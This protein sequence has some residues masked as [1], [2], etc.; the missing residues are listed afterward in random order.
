MAHYNELSCKLWTGDE[1]GIEGE[2]GKL[3]HDILSC[4]WMTWEYLKQYFEVSITRTILHEF[5][6]QNL[7]WY[8]GNP[9]ND[10]LVRDFVHDAMYQNIPVGNISQYKEG[11]DHD[12]PITKQEWKRWEKQ[13][14][15]K[16]R[17]HWRLEKA[18]LVDSK[19]GDELDAESDLAYGTGSQA[20]QSTIG[21]VPGKHQ[22]RS[23][24]REARHF[25]SSALVAR[26]W[27]LEDGKSHAS[28]ITGRRTG[29]VLIGT[30]IAWEGE[31][32]GFRQW[33]RRYKAL[34]CA[35]CQIPA[36]LL[37]GPWTD[38]KLHFL[39][40]VLEGGAHI[41]SHGYR[42]LAGR[43]LMDAI[44]DDNH[45]AV[46][47]LAAVG[48]DEQYVDPH[49]MDGMYAKPSLSEAS[50]SFSSLCE[51]TDAY[52]RISHLERRTCGV[53]PTTEHL[54][55]AVIEKGCRK[56]IVRR[57][58]FAQGAETDT[59]D[60]SIKEWLLARTEMGDSKAGWLQYQMETSA[61]LQAQR[62]AEGSDND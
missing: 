40:A 36:K 25:H 37:T 8:D 57:L 2:I 20:G 1:S 50:F 38:S 46:D 44:R 7:R 6:E 39:E 54:K 19:L 43:G 60:L 29:L 42:D 49:R 14:I 23:S 33:N 5:S 4:R 32:N 26:S 30:L 61:E 48:C 31:M 12:P 10:S 34:F 9:L 15:A 47:M 13:H 35:S 55:V 56:M 59:Q 51:G 28:F 24:K 17:E 22:T 58:L 62:L 3:Q 11:L 16:S 52:V 45:R 18:G 53:V 41:T 27:E 21:L